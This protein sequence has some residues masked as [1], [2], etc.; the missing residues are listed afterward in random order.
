MVI[1]QFI[2]ET[3][4]LADFAMNSK[5]SLGYGCS[6]FSIEMTLEVITET[7]HPELQH[8]IVMLSCFQNLQGKLLTHIQVLN[9]ILSNLNVYII[10]DIK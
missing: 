10:S 1:K 6:V 5:N 8:H 3:Q 9:N 2:D 4:I 7:S